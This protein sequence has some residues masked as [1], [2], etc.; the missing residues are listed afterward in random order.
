MLKS[1]LKNAAMG[2]LMGFFLHLIFW[3]F[4]THGAILRCLVITNFIF[5]LKGSP[6]PCSASYFLV[7]FSESILMI[8][9]FCCLNAI[10][11]GTTIHICW[12]NPHFAW[13]NHINQL[14]K[15]H[16]T[17]ILSRFNRTSTI[18]CCEHLDVSI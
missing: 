11:D 10:V 13:L 9:V 7:L 6:S 18:F 15:C 1:P 8:P 17:T 4:V 5:M 14:Y 2:F 3:I 16:K 12:L